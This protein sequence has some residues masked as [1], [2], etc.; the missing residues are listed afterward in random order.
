MNGKKRSFRLTSDLPREWKKQHTLRPMPT[1]IPHQNVESHRPAGQDRERDA[2]RPTHPPITGVNKKQE[3]QSDQKK[4]YIT[5]LPD[6]LRKQKNLTSPPSPFQPP[7]THYHPLPHIPA[8]K[9]QARAPADETP[10]CL[11]AAT[12]HPAAGEYYLCSG[13]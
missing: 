12:S 4:R 9:P 11:P 7:P 2:P 6:S 5:N 13:D 8:R 1:G 10:D 3:T